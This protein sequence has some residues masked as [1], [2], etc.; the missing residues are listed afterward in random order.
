M[1]WACSAIPVSEYQRSILKRDADQISY[2]NSKWFNLMLAEL[3]FFSASCKHVPSFQWCDNRCRSFLPHSNVMKPHVA[4][5]F[6]IWD[7]QQLPLQ[8]HVHVAGLHSERHQRSRGSLSPLITHPIPVLKKQDVR[9]GWV[10]QLF[11]PGEW[12][13]PELFSAGG[14]W[15]VLRGTFSGMAFPISGHCGHTDNSDSTGR[16]SFMKKEQ[17]TDQAVCMEFAFG[18]SL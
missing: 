12:L 16:W 10:A 4:Q 1:G 2:T 3:S 5:S 8:I 17:K 6:C 13:Q 7:S 18:N 9:N 11:Q 15:T 14:P